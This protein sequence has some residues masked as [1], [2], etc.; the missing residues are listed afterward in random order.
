MEIKLVEFVMLAYRLFVSS[1]FRKGQSIIAANM[2]LIGRIS[3][4]D[5][6]N[7]GRR[8]VGKNAVVEIKERDRPGRADT[9][10]KMYV[11]V[12]A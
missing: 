11:H 9:Q 8:I 1:R 4:L 7:S 3:T 12:N 6:L 10:P 2:R 5:N